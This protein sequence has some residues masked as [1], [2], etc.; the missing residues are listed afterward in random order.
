MSIFSKVLIK[1]PLDIIHYI[2]T[3]FHN[4]G[5]APPFIW[6]FSPT[7]YPA[8]SAYMTLLPE[9]LCIG[10]HTAEKVMEPPVEILI[11]IL[12]LSSPTDLP[13]DRMRAGETFVGREQIYETR[14]RFISATLGSWFASA[15]SLRRC[16]AL[17]VRQREMS[18]ESKNVLD[19]FV[20]TI[21]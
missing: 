20:H 13:K 16:S 15:I 7:G 18:S 5:T 1:Y 21:Y 2:F 19:Q 12:A 6:T 9:T 14:S 17:F 10:V 3:R 4:C 8:A 11:A